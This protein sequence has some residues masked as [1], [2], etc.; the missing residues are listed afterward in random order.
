MILTLL[1][2]CHNEA[3]N[4]SLLVQRVA[5]ALVDIGYEMILIDD[6]SNDDTLTVIK[7]IAEND[8]RIEYIR[9]SRNF[10]H[11]AALKAGIVHAKGDCIVTMDADLQ[12]PPEKIPEMIALWQQG[13]GVVNARRNGNGERGF[14]KRITA[15]VYYKLLNKLTDENIPE[16]VADFRLFDR[17]V[18]DVIRALPEGNLYLRGLFAWVGFMQTTITYNEGKR[19]H[20]D[21]KYNLWRM[22]RLA[23]NGITSFSTKPLR[24]SLT[25]GVTFAFIAFAYGIYAI[26]M[27]LAGHTV[28]G[29]TSVI[30]SILF[31]SGI[32]L[33]VLGILGEYLGKLFMENKRRPV[34]I[35]KESSLDSEQ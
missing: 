11:Q 30:A 8:N 21:T 27:L 18:A 15:K 14:I 31:L 26:V 29:W 12:H 22:L 17:K 1:I 23:G 6:G 13:Y 32:Q 24:L 3:G 20:G 4:I 19:K 9:M 33:I 16:G 7:Q 28:T 35:V 5:E 25:I 10:G 2:P 34:Y